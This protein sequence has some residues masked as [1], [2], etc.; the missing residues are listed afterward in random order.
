MQ[1]YD[2]IVC[3]Q[4]LGDIVSIAASPD[5]KFVFA[6]NSDGHLYCV[7]ASSRS[8]VAEWTPEDPS[9]AAAGGSQEQSILSSLSVVVFSDDAYLIT[10]IDTSGLLLLYSCMP[11][12]MS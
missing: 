5:S 1:S 4:E 3:Y 12:L 7:E 10:A 11:L 6:S 8:V 9:A 2:D